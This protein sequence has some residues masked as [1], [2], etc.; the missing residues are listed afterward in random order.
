MEHSG[1]VHV[2]KNTQ[3]NINLGDGIWMV[4][5]FPGVISGKESACQCRKHKTLVQSLGREDPLEGAW[6]SLQCACLK[7][8]HG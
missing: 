5:G 6:H 4:T 3:H 7:N 1:M 2:Q 8:P